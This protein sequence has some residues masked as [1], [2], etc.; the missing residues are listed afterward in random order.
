MRPLVPALLLAVALGGAGCFGGG[1]DGPPPLVPYPRSG[2]VAVY[3]ATGALVEFA[4]WNNGVPFAAVSAQVRLT[5]ATSPDALDGARAQHPAFK[6]TTDVAEAG[7]FGKRH[8]RWVGPRQEAIV[9]SFYPLSQD[10]SVVAFDERGYPWMFGA[11]VLI[12]E[13][14]T[15]GARFPFDI[16]DNLGRGATMQMAWVV[17]GDEE[18]FT[19]LTLDAPASGMTGALWMEPGSPWPARVELAIVTDELAPHVRSDG[20]YPVSMGARRVSVESSGESLPPRDRGAV[21]IGDSSAVRTEYDGEKPPDGD[22][23][24]L[25]YPLGEAVEN[26]KVIDPSLRAWLDA[27]DAPLLYRATYQIEPGALEGSQSAHWL[28]QFVDRA[29]RY[30]ET[31]ISRLHAPPL[32]VGVPRIE[33]SA[34]AQP[35]EEENHGWFD[36]ADVPQMQV[37]LSEGIR[38]V[39]DV[40]GATEVQIFLRSFVDPPGY[41]YYLDGGFVE[42]EAGRYTVIYNPSTGFIES[43]TGPVTPRLAG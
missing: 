30:Y 22:P 39:R 6:V 32:P 17:A 24:T 33:A 26:A 38:I 15:E 19:K 25:L 3:E 12:G 29:E 9:Q 10:Q 18:G 11:S 1:D 2:D 13:E 5:L 34:P 14:L 7:V 42:G 20:G 41:S 4:R 36:P 40:F 8:D 23:A 28:V 43:A 37:P 16:P 35:P 27:A 21:F 31:Q